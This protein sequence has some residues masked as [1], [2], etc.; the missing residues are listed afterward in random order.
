MPDVDDSKEDKSEVKQ[1]LQEVPVADK[2]E[3]FC[4]KI[5]L[6]VTIRMTQ[7]LLYSLHGM[8]KMNVYVICLL[9]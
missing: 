9:V 8:H 2:L 1:C 5:T 6:Q 3:D 4:H 7:L